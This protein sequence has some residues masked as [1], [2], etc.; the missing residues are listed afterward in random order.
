MIEREQTDMENIHTA[1]G[2][3]RWSM[4][5]DEKAEM[6]SCTWTD[7]F[8][9]M[10]GYESKA[11]FPDKLESWSDLLHKEDKAWV[12]KEYWDTVK[13]YTGKK[14]YDVEYRLLTRH[15]GWRWFHAAGRLSRREDGSPI[16]FIGLFVDIDDEKR[17]E[18]QLE[19]QKTNLQDA[20]YVF[21]PV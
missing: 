6:I 12:L 20:S 18:E 7:V 4:E 17:M 10:L 14:T 11:D 19:K 2:S 3:G 8:R 13:D 1:M 9:E 15:G 16:T 5:F 21:F